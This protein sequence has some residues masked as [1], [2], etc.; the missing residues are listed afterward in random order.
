[1]KLCSR[2]I[3]SGSAK[4]VC[5]IHTVQNAPPGVSAPGSAAAERQVARELQQRDQRH[6]ERHDLQ[7]EDRE[8]QRRRGPGTSS[9]QRVGR[10]GGEEDRDERRRDRDDER[11][12]EVRREADAAAA[13]GQHVLVVVQR[14]AGFVN[15]VHQPLVVDVCSSGRNEV[16]N[17]PNVG[18]VQRTVMMTPRS[19][20]TAS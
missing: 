1:M 11:V 8:E 17:R 9:R 18:M 3:A 14:E 20:P 16:M 2:K 4:I 13:A 19:R 7:R 6:L 15:N 10:H 5:A 12:D